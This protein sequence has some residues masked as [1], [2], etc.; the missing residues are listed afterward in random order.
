MTKPFPRASRRK[1][2][3][4]QHPHGHRRADDVGATS[5]E[6]DARRERRH[7]RTPAGTSFLLALGVSA[8]VAMG[9]VRVRAS[10]RVLELGAEITALTD[11]QSELLEQRRRLQAE[12][13]YLRHPDQI[14]EIARDRLGMVPIAPEL[15]QRIRVEDTPR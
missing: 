4:V 7:L 3:P 8:L 2:K 11:L 12:R 15:V 9:L 10:A 5:P 6:L 1:Q 14:R 13:A